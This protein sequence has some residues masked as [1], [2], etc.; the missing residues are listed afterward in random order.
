LRKGEKVNRQRNLLI[1]GAVLHLGQMA[2]HLLLRRSELVLRSNALELDETVVRQVLGY[3]VRS[4]QMAD[5][6]EGIARWRLLEER[7]K[8]SVRQT[9][10]ALKWLVEQGFVEELR[11]TGLRSSVFRLNPQRLKE[12]KQ[13]LTRGK[14]RRNGL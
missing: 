11:P 9:D 10:A 6:L 5:T 8:L 1:S 7:V 14:K 2:L 4:R 12:A 13:F 3:F